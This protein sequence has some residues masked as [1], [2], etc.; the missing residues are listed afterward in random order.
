MKRT[1]D[2][3]L[4]FSSP[5][6]EEVLSNAKRRGRGL[7][8]P[9]KSTH[10]SVVEASLYANECFDP[11][12]RDEYRAQAATFP[13]DG[14]RFKKTRHNY[15]AEAREASESWW[16]VTGSNRRPYRC[17]RYALPAELTAL[18]AVLH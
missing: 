17:K 14:G 7:R 8:N 6:Y 16:A 15:I 12:N 5:A 13:I 3:P 4:T 9:R 11:E 1:R 2:D 18:R 10:N